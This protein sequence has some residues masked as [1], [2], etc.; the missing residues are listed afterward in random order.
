MDWRQPISYH[1]LLNEPLALC[2]RERESER[3]RWNLSKIASFDVLSSI[4]KDW[5]FSMWSMAKRMFSTCFSYVLFA[6]EW[7][8]KTDKQKMFYTHL[9]LSL[10][11]SRAS[12]TSQLLLCYG[13][14]L[15]SSS[16]F[17]FALDKCSR[18]ELPLWKIS[19]HK[20]WFSFFREYSLYLTMRT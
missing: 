17:R 5:N 8:P 7:S 2:V 15:S 3:A 4:R 14:F 18:S 11:A 12:R 1:H 16:S 20:L 13:P 19:Q 9:S 10:L 6:V